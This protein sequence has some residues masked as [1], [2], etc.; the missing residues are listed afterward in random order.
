MKTE[1]KWPLV[2]VIMAVRNGE[3]FLAEAIRSVRAQNYPAH[4]IIVVDGHSTDRTAE[5]ARSFSGVKFLTQPG[6]GVSAA[7]NFG[8]AVARGDWIA[9]LE[10]DDIWTPE[11][12]R[13]QILFMQRRPELQFTLTHARLFLEP[14]C[15]WP[16]GYNP[17]WLK[18]PQI[19]AILSSLVARKKVF[20]QIGKF[21]E[22]L[23]C[24]GDVDWFSRAKDLQIPM[25]YLEE[26]LLL[27]RVHD[28]NVTSQTQL[29]NVELL[30][31]I[32][33]TLDRKRI[34][35]PAHA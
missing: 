24:A 9:V 7:L 35:E 19:G 14:G 16:S 4:E 12:L 34:M 1:I 31:V 2:S 22:H 21:D 8:I 27:K 13:T 20:E 5:I 30:Q 10:H 26:T 6:R 11:K 17:D 28:R 25:A 3:R 29:N 32:K 23:Q 18:E 33:R 15:A